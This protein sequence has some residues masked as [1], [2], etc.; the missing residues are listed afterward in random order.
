VAEYEKFPEPVNTIE[1][2][3]VFTTLPWFVSFSINLDN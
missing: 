3:T 1:D 2:A